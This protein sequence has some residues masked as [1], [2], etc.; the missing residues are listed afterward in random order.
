MSKR[1]IIGVMGPG[2]HATNEDK[3]IAFEIG[4]TI[5]RLGFILLT[6]G[7]NVGV[8]HAASEGAKK[9]KGITLGILPGENEDAVSE[10]VDIPVLTGMGNARNAINVLSSKVIVSIGEGPGTFSEIVLALK[11]NKPVIAY[12]LS[13]QALG[14]FNRL[15]KRTILAVNSFDE[16]MFK[17]ILCKTIDNH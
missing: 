1:T 16:K 6:G 9:E 3:R 7:R 14:L 17:D 13:P 5:A 11:I 15:Q 10:F 2:E 8:M 4:K 12:N